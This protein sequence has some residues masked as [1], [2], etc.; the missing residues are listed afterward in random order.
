MQYW[1]D[2]WEV[3]RIEGHHSLQVITQ[4]KEVVDKSTERLTKLVEFQ[5]ED[6]TGREGAEMED[7]EQPMDEEQR[8]SVENNQ[9]LRERWKIHKE[10]EDKKE[11]DREAIKRSLRSRSG[12]PKPGVGVAEEPEGLIKA[13]QEQQEP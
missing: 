13:K 9:K 10:V 7:G 1:Q 11:R 3:S 2:K 4:W 5:K 8:A 6:I 12:S